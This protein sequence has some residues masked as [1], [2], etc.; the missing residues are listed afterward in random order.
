MEEI[1]KECLR[2]LGKG[3][4]QEIIRGKEEE[5]GKFCCYGEEKKNE[6]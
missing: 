3:R 4:N 2:R 1:Y 6:D 5:V